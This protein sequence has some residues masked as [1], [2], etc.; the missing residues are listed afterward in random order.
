MIEAR[1]DAFLGRFDYEPIFNGK[2]PIPAHKHI[3]PAYAKI[4]TENKK[5]RLL[6][7]RK[8]VIEKFNKKYL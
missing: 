1:S 3:D 6:F 7:R 2:I 5:I 8:Y 4:K